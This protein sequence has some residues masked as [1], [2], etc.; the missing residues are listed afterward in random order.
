DSHLRPEPPLRADRFSEPSRPRA[1]RGEAMA[2][3]ENSARKQ[4]RATYTPLRIP[5][6]RKPTIGRAR[7]KYALAVRLQ[8]TPSELERLTRRQP[9][10]PAV[11]AALARTPG[12]HTGSPL[13]EAVP[14]FAE[15]DWP[16]L[17]AIAER[18]GQ[19]REEDLAAL[20]GIKTALPSRGGALISRRSRSTR[21]P[22]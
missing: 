17:T 2:E 9:I 13:V 1:A 14:P 18:L 21:N 12:P 3:L 8:I 6:D 5:D 4:L 15:I 20:R 7:A 10:D 19:L 11:R 16:A 22:D